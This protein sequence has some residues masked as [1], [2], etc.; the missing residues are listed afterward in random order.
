MPPCIK[1]QNIHLTTI[2]TNSI[3][4]EKGPKKITS[5]ELEG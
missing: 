3:V 4:I 2:N 1:D 5:M